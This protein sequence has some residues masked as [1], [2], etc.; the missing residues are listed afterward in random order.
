VNYEFNISRV[1]GWAFVNN[2]LER[3]AKKLMTANQKIL[4]DSAS[5]AA[6]QA[7]NFLPLTRLF[8]LLDCENF[9]NSE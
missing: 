8:V 7:I 5:K 2:T 4:I 1:Q 9:N 6:S 3:V